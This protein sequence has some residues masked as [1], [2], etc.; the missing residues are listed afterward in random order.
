[1]NRNFY[2]FRNCALAFLLAGFV[3][4]NPNTSANDDQDHDATGDST[5]KNDVAPGTVALRQSAIATIDATYTDTTLTGK[6]EFTT[7]SDGSVKMVLTLNIPSKANKSVA[8]HIHENGECGDHGKAAGGHWNPT[9]DEHGKWGS[10]HFHRG[11]I[12]NVKL[13]GSGKGSMEMKTDLWQLGGDETRNILGKSIIVHGGVDDFVSQ[14]SG[15][16]GARIGC[17]V[18]K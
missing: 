12:G 5:S 8:V 16:A 11:D 14:P 10:A 13:D 1:M 7:E 4:C 9:N 2:L 3:A 6:A 15:N 18:I 17:G